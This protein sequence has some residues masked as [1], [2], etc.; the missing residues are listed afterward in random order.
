MPGGEQAT[1]DSW[2]SAGLL[3]YGG[4]KAGKALGAGNRYT[5]IA[6]LNNLSNPNKIR[7]GQVLL[8]PE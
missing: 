1:G 6:T 2:L 3:A 7:A 5:E 8:L 4:I